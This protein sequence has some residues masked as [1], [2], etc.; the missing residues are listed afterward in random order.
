MNEWW[1]NRWFR[2]HILFVPFGVFIT[3]GL[4]SYFIE[5]GPWNIRAGLKSAAS[6]VDLGTIVYA[7]VAVFIERV[8][9]MWFWALDQ[10]EKWREKWR[11]EAQAEGRAEGRS[12]GHAAGRADLLN[13]MWAVAHAEDNQEFAAQVERV[14]R[15]EGITLDE[16]TPR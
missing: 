12:E 7:M 13:R 15:E 2:R 9:R 3:T 6:L 8:I 14:A 5:P 1:Q 16:L 4:L 10:R 11:R